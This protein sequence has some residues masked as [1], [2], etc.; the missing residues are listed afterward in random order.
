MFEAFE[1]SFPSHV[2]S[3]SAFSSPEAPS[4]AYISQVLPPQ[5][6]AIEAVTT[7][8]Q[9]IHE[10]SEDISS[11]PVSGQTDDSSA[12]PVRLLR[13]RRGRPTRCGELLSQREEQSYHSS[14]P[15]RLSAHPPTTITTTTTTTI[16]FSLSSR[17]EEPLQTDIHWNWYS[18]LFFFLF[19]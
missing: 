9:A 10:H 5:A 17:V 6:K 4:E 1:F 15:D 11:R 13:H 18:Y 7:P 3:P 8:A 12:A 14:G 16:P 2:F 19:F